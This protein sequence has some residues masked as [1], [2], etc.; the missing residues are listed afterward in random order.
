MAH[1]ALTSDY[2]SRVAKG[3]AGLKASLDQVE[4]NTKDGPTLPFLSVL[5]EN[6]NVGYAVGSFGMLVRTE[7]G[8]KSWHPWL[9]HID[10][11]SFLNL[12][13]IREVSGGIYIVGEQ[14]SVFRLD[15]NLNRFVS[16]ATSYKGSFFRIVGNDRFLLVVG[17]NGT[18]Y[19]SVD[20]GAS[21]KSVPT[22]ATT[23]LTSA[24]LSSDGAMLLLTSEGGGLL[25]SKDDGNS[26]KDLHAEMPMLYADALASNGDWFVLA[27]Y[28]GV[29]RQKVRPVTM[30]NPDTK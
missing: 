27:G 26:F 19:R 16:I 7:D 13:D 20:S 28:Q 3:E 17:L 21:W 30:A 11:G 14:G 18:A 5:F 1:G 22:G 24:S 8:G 10:N 29:A 23:S 4:L 9:D 2:K 25:C 12:N 15:R 6:E